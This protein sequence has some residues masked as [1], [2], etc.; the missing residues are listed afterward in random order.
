MILC[1]EAIQVF[2]ILPDLI[3]LQPVSADPRIRYES[4]QNSDL[5]WIA[6]GNGP[7][8]DPKCWIHFSHI[9]FCK[10]GDFLLKK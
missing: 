1:K 9:I 6:A 4:C 3:V 10:K 7:E 5:A 8:T 2:T